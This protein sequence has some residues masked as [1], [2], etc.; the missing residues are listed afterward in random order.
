MS[1][2]ATHHVF[3]RALRVKRLTAPYHDIILIFSEM[4]KERGVERNFCFILNLFS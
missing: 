3:I 4:G 2:Q 1:V